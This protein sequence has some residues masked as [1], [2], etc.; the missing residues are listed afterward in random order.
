MSLAGP[1]CLAAA[2]RES[3]NDWQQPARVVT[4]LG[5]K[6]GTRIAD[7]G[8]G[9]GYF[10]FRLGQAVGPKGKVFATEISAKSLKAITDR[11]KKDK[12]ANIETVLSGP[13]D[14]KL[15][16]DSVDSALICN[17]L[18]HVSKDKHLALTKDVV[19]AIRPGGFLFIIDWR[20]DAKISHDRHRRIKRDDFVKLA[21]DVGLVLD[22]EY[23]YLKNQVFLRFRKPGKAK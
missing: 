11:V 9:R 17:V 18:H 13:T 4:D 6:S 5:L 10:T 22:A 2:R 21:K 19:R 12:L 7:I 20:A 16:S 14:T 1:L 15:K 23:H 3:R 8:A